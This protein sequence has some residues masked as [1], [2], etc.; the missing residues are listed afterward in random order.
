MWENVARGHLKPIRFQEN[1]IKKN[2]LADKPRVLL[3]LFLWEGK[4]VWTLFLENQQTP[5]HAAL[6]S[7]SRLCSMWMAAATFSL[8]HIHTHK[9]KLQR[10]KFF[11]NPKTLRAREIMC[12]CKNKL[13]ITRHKL[14]CAARP[15]QRARIIQPFVSFALQHRAKQ[16][17]KSAACS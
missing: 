14:C 11:K 5:T 12:V 13:Y 16:S 17:H 7:F 8:S 2:F 4:E 6:L 1:A 10:G 9:P 3:R 15:T